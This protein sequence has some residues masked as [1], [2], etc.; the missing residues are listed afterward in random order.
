MA[1]KSAPRGR[2]PRRRRVAVEARPTA[3]AC[4]A[5]ALAL[6]GD[7]V[8]PVFEAAGGM[9]AEQ[10]EHRHADGQN[11][12][13]RHAQQVAVDAKEK[14]TPDGEEHTGGRGPVCRAVDTS[15]AQAVV[16][17]SKRSASASA[18]RSSNS[19]RF[20]ANLVSRS[21]SLCVLLHDSFAT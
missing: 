9:L 21:S 3:E 1:E 6:H 4:Q 13:H 8:D 19:R 11:P 7:N 20:R 12:E 18:V 15:S 14:V 17:T 16:P 10:Y 5:D 2:R